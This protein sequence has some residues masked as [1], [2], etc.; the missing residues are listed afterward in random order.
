MKA[1]KLDG[2]ADLAGT[3]LSQKK[4]ASLVCKAQSTVKRWREMPRY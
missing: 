3:P 2:E 1:S 4:L